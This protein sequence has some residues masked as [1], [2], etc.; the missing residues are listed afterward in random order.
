MYLIYLSLSVSGLSLSPLSISSENFFITFNQH[1]CRNTVFQIPRSMTGFQLHAITPVLVCVVNTITQPS[2]CHSSL[3]ILKEVRNRFTILIIH[4]YMYIHTHTHTQ[5]FEMVKG[6]PVFMLN[7]GLF[8][9][10]CQMIALAP[11][12]S[13]LSK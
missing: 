2:L 10:I 12:T 6:M 7:N 3:C 5:L 11:E 1:T 4:M 8:K 13:S 9:M